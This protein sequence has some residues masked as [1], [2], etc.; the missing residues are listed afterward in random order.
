MT[1]DPVSAPIYSAGMCVKRR[2]PGI[3]YP[4]IIGIV[5]V[6]LAYL[7]SRQMGLALI[8]PPL[9][10]SRIRV[11]ISESRLFTHKVLNE[12]VRHII[13]DSSFMRGCEI[14]EI[15]Y[16]EHDY[17]NDFSKPSNKDVEG[18]QASFVMEYACSSF[19]SRTMSMS[20]ADSVVW[21]L[22]YNPSDST[23]GTGWETIAH[24]NG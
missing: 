18:T 16:T 23:D 3:V 7:I 6:V 2:A 4:L 15:S 24:G 20:P 17:Y 10:S 8:Q 22:M 13:N 14:K 9:D 12:G 11:S 5:V 21:R 19:N 1:A